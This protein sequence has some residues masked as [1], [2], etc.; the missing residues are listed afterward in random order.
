MFFGY[1]NQ[2]SIHFLN[3]YRYRTNATVCLFYIDSAYLCQDALD[4]SQI[5]LS[6]LFTVLD[7]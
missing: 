3:R 4:F 2:I 5:F 7:P 1:E 6:L